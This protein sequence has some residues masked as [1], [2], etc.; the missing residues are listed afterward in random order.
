MSDDLTARADERLQAALTETGAR[1]PRDACRALLR[2][3][4]GQDEAAYPR[5]VSRWRSGVIEPLGRG[6]GDPLSLWLEFGV[7]LAATLHPGRPM[8]VDTQ[9]TATPLEGS[10][11]WNTLVLHL[12]DDPRHRAIPVVL[13]PAPSAAQQATMDLLV[14]GRLSLEGA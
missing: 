6:E 3:L 5:L 8:V 2:E 11:E 9:G 7:E 12:P 14:E 13:P 10:P 1:D 4:K